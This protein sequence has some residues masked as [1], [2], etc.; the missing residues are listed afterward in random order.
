LTDFIPTLKVQPWPHQS[1]RE[2]MD[3]FYGD[4]R[5]PGG[6]ESKQWVTEYLVPVVPPWKMVYAENGKRIT[7]FQFNNQ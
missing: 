7:R 1:S 3:A 2:E 4:P 6:K 5:G